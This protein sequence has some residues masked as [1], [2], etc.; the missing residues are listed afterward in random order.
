[1][2]PKDDKHIFSVADQPDGYAT[3]IVRRLGRF[4]VFTWTVTALMTIYA[5]FG[6]DLQRLLPGQ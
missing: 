1:V 6:A 3:T 5:F 2:F 4:I